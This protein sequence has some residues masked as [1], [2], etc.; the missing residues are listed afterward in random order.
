M[1]KPISGCEGQIGCNA[2]IVDV[3]LSEW[4]AYLTNA[5]L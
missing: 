1:L 4:M 3:K 2:E 5:S